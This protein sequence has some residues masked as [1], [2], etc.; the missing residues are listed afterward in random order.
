MSSPSLRIMIGGRTRLESGPRQTWQKSR[1]GPAALSN[2]LSIGF[3]MAT[4]CGYGPAL[5]GIERQPGGT[6]RS[7]HKQ[8]W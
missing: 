8:E 4:P 5:D 6:C 1:S 2:A 7:D 3:T